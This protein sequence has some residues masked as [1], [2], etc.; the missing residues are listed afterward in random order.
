MSKR[1]KAN[2]TEQTAVINAELFDRPPHGLDE[3]NLARWYRF[4]ADYHSARDLNE[5]PFPLQVDFEINSTCN[6]RCSFCL[7]GHENVPVAELGFDRFCRIIDEG[8][9]YGLVS[10]KMNYINEPLL[11]RDLERYIRYARDKGILNV[12]FATNGSLLNEA[13]SRSIIEAGVTKIMVS[14]DAITPETFKLMRQSTL[15]S[16]IVKNILDFLRVREEM[17]VSQPLLRVNFL[18]TRV[19]M[20]EAEEFIRFW[21]DKADMIGFQNQVGIPGIDSNIIPAT[22]VISPA[23]VLDNNKSR[24]RCSFPFKLLVVDS[25]G[26][27]LPCCTF[28]GR[29]MPLGDIDTMTLKDAWTSLQMRE[30]RLL[31]KR[32]GYRENPI[33]FHCVNSNGVDGVE[34]T[35]G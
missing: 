8:Q 22:D 32:G 31:H 15:Y 1:F 26:N 20:H 18:K 29:A 4:R 24:F 21:Q 7:H 19:N 33:C 17:G 13:R 10:I 25:N 12:Y 23:E 6:M 5:F 34:N 11:V 35:G 27:I 14:L 2:P 16:K 9:K 28:S 30:L 3:A